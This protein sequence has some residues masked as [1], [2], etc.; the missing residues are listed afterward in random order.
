MSVCWK[1]L[2]V[3]VMPAFLSVS[4]GKQ[5][6]EVGPQHS[7]PVRNHS[8]EFARQWMEL[9]YELVRAERRAPPVASRIYAYAAIALYES[10]V[11]GMPHHR[12]LSGQ[13]EGMPAMPDRP[14]GQTI[15]WPT[16]SATTIA[17]TGAWLFFEGDSQ[18]AIG[19]LFERQLEAR[20]AAE[21]SEVVIERSRLYGEELAE[22][23][24]AWAAQDGYDTLSNQL[25]SPPSTGAHAWVPTAE[26]MQ[27]LQPFWSSL[28]PFALTRADVCAPP[29]P[30]AFSSEADS[31]FFREAMDVYEVSHSMSEEEATI[32]RFWS[33]DP[34]TT[35][36]PSGHWI[37]IGSGLVDQLELGLDEAVEMYALVGIAGADAFISC[38]DEKFRSYLLR[39][40]TYIQRHIDPEWRPLLNTPP[41]PEYTS[42]HSNV[43][44]AA[45]M[46]L[47][48]LFGEIA[49]V[50]NTRESIGMAPRA[51]NSF[52]E[53][54]EEA[55]VSRLYGGIHY[56]MGIEHGV[57][58]GACVGQA[59]L[60]RLRTRH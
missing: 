11:E 27:P 45:A 49:F 58:Q 2:M 51:F 32:A 48:H 46:V 44:G 26:G 25:F 54:A 28:R 43:S 4:C 19:E 56:P 16:V 35:G 37:A 21:I 17:M 9:S 29:A 8:G 5:T 52:A 57:P 7:E 60:H 13:I 33:D 30:V 53:A 10:V 41:F 24:G 18:L 42:G 47:T 59:V 50:D 31:A 40:V 39:P 38:W 34:G 15:D 6:T 14:F 1:L 55:A 3:L 12:S 22:A 23:I 36:T 20:R